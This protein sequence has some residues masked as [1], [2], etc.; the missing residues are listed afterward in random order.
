[1]VRKNAYL[2]K[3]VNRE[4]APRH[5]NPWH[6]IVYAAKWLAPIFAGFLGVLLWLRHRYAWNSVRDQRSRRRNGGSDLLERSLMVGFL[7]VSILGAAGSFGH[8]LPVWVS[9]SHTINVEPKTQNVL[10]SAA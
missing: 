8:A 10:T 6:T 9:L 3:V 4:I 2:K 5:A 7:S 1:L